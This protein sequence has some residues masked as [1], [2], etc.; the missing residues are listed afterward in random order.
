[1]D[2]KG[3][4]EGILLVEDQQQTTR[5][6]EENKSS[7]EANTSENSY[8]QPDVIVQVNE[9][10]ERRNDKEEENKEE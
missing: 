3:K 5:N 10:N 4:F 7:Q 8:K 1:M 6:L 2:I 9:T